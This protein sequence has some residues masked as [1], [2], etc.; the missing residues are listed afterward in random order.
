MVQR[1]CETLDLGTFTGIAPHHPVQLNNESNGVD[2]AVEVNLIY[3]RMG[4][5]DFQ[6]SKTASM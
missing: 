1:V 4:L 2:G 3:L 6:R 5:S